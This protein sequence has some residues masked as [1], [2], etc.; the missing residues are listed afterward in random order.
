MSTTLSN[1]LDDADSLAKKLGAELHAEQD[2]LTLKQRFLNLF[3]H[4]APTIVEAALRE[5]VTLA[6]GGA[7]LPPP[8]AQ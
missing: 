8:M 6:G 4:Y 5:A 2:P 1:A 3:L 7:V